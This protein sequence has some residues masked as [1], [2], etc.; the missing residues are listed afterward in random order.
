MRSFICRSSA[1]D[2]ILC[3]ASDRGLGNLRPRTRQL[4][5]RHCFTFGWYIVVVE[6]TK[7]DLYNGV[8][9]R[10]QK[11]NRFMEVDVR[12]IAS[13]VLVFADSHFCLSHL[14]HGCSNGLPRHYGW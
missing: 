5:A 2:T 10:E 11:M 7:L 1:R 14:C 12:C 4:A 3:C 6:E 13:I 8:D 9:G